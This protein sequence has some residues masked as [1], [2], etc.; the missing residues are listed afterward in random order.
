[1]QSWRKINRDT[2]KLSNKN[3]LDIKEPSKVFGFYKTYNET[4]FEELK[5][6]QKH[7]KDRRMIK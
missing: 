5:R 3:E 1:M 2:S 6:I 4:D 7:I